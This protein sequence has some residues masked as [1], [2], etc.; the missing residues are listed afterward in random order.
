MIAMLFLFNSFPSRWDVLGL[1]EVFGWKNRH[2]CI[3]RRFRKKMFL[4]S[5]ELDKKTA[6]EKVKCSSEPADSTRMARFCDVIL[7]S[8]ATIK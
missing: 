4:K 2:V 7:C 3:F 1:F 8:L 6:K 5:I